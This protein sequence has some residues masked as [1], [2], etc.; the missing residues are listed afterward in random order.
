VTRV[1]ARGGSSWAR[2]AAWFALA[3]LAGAQLLVGLHFAL[4]PHVLCAEQGGLG[5]A[6]RAH[7]AP[8]VT[9]PL[10]APPDGT[11]HAAPDQSTFAFEHC[12]L[13][14]GAVQSTAPVPVAMGV[15]GA[16]SRWLEPAR[17]QVRAAVTSIALLALAPKQSPPAGRA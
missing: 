5:H 7:A 14:L 17:A 9:D 2:C 13:P 4:V 10:P 6:V 1:E 15:A 3:V 11:S 12:S 16:A 8:E